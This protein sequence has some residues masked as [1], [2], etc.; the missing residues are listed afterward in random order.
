MRCESGLC[1][2]NEREEYLYIDS[3]SVMKRFKVRSP[4][5]LKAPQRLHTPVT[6]ASGRA[7][8]PLWNRPAPSPVGWVKETDDDRPEPEQSGKE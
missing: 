7:F 2:C 4:D 5:N 1:F 6:L 8:L 3:V